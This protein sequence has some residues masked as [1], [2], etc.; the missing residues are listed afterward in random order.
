MVLHVSQSV[1]RY[2]QQQQQ[3]Q[4]SMPSLLSKWNG[5][6]NAA[7]AFVNQAGGNLRWRSVL[8]WRNKEICNKIRPFKFDRK[9]PA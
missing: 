7:S 5:E 3:Q 1:C 9:K 2:E 8:Y 6:P 4:L